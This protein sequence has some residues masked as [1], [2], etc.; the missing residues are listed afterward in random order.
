MKGIFLALALAVITTG[1]STV[2][3]TKIQLPTHGEQHT[4]GVG[5]AV[6][7]YQYV[8]EHVDDA[9]YG[10]KRPVGGYGTGEVD[11]RPNVQAL[12]YSGIAN[13]QLVFDYS[14]TGP[15]LG[16]F[17]AGAQ[18]DYSPGTR[19]TYKGASITV[20]AADN[21]QIT[22]IVNRGFSNEVPD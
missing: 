7:K 6:Y 11:V 8:P 17:S 16:N 3:A 22:Y 18:Y 15:A 14:Q 5:D 2:P 13:E 19:V 21:Q 1:C 10:K 20:V 9:W 12:I 4:V